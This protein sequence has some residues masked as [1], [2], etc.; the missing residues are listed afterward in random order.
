[1]FQKLSAVLACLLLFSV[2]PVM[3]QVDFCDGNFD[4]NKT[5]DGIDA[6][7][8]KSNFG[9]SKYNNPCPPDGPSPIPTTGAYDPYSAY[10]EDG[11]LRRG[12]TWP[13]PRFTD[14]TPDGTVTDNLT[15]LMWFKDA[16]WIGS[17]T[18]YDAFF[19]VDQINIVCGQGYCDWRVPNIRELHS[20]IDFGQYNPALTP[21]RPFE[22]VQSLDYWTSTTDITDSQRAWLVFMGNGYLNLYNKTSLGYL[23]PVRGGH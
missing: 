5:V 7:V 4:F 20:L 15:G 23:W 1:M 6:G 11:L 3:A 2:T 14:N 16:N 12:V 13:Y 22:N 8:F 9:R 17:L 10:L 21:E 19:W 18:W